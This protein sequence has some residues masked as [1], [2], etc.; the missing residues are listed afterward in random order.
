MYVLLYGCPS[1][2]FLDAEPAATGER[3]RGRARGVPAAHPRQRRGGDEPQ[4]LLRAGE[5]QEQGGEGKG[6]EGRAAC[7]DK[8]NGH[9]VFSFS[10]LTRPQI[11]IL[12][13]VCMYA[14][15]DHVNIWLNYLSHLF[16]TSKSCLLQSTILFARRHFFGSAVFQQC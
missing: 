6:R 1:F 2:S 15:R 16:R 9:C 12:T 3:A 14:W 4:G 5:G 10:L 8:I 11:N 7:C 13:C